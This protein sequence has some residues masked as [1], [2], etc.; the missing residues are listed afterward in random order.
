MNKYCKLSN[1]VETY[2]HRDAVFN[3]QKSLH[4]CNQTNHVPFYK[5]TNKYCKLLNS[6]DTYVHRDA[7]FNLQKYL[8]NCNNQTIYVPIYKLQNQGTG[9]SKLLNSVATYVH[10]DAVLNLQKFLAQFQQCN[11]TKNVSIYNST[12]CKTK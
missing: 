2:V 8:H 7:V 11:Q 6:V 1:S 9:N 3:L 10:R 4:N 12:C 5:L